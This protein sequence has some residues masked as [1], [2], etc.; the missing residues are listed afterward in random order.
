MEINIQ[1]RNNSCEIN[2]KKNN[3]IV[4]SKINQPLGAR[5]FEKYVIKI[6]KK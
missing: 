4:L 1:R 5:H 3:K 6:I 2:P